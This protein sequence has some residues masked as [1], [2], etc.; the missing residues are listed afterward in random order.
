MRSYNGSQMPKSE[1]LPHLQPEK[2]RCYNQLHQSE[3]ESYILNERHNEQVQHHAA[4]GTEDM[5]AAGKEEHCPEV[6]PIQQA[7]DDWKGH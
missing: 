4:T 7:L 3:S 5:P 6:L 2:E 1:V